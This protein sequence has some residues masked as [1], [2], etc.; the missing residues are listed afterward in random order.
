[1]VKPAMLRPPVR[2]DRL[3]VALLLANP[4]P[5]ELLADAELVDPLD[6]KAVR[7]TTSPTT[8][9]RAHAD[10]S[11]VARLGLHDRSEREVRSLAV[12]VVIISPSPLVS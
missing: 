9:V 6:P 7:M 12:L 10:R 2:P 4:E 11:N 5:V 1:M 8:P 3:P